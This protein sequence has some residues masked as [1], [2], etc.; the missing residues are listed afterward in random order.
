MFLSDAI[1]DY[2]Y[3]THAK[4]THTQDTREKKV[5]LPRT[6][7]QGDLIDISQIPYITQGPLLHLISSSSSSFPLIPPLP[8]HSLPSS[9]TNMSKFIKS[10]LALVTLAL[11]CLV[12]LTTVKAADADETRESYGTVIGIGKSPPPLTLFCLSACFLV[13]FPCFSLVL[14]LA[15][16]S[17]PAF[18][19]QH[20]L[21]TRNT[22]K[23]G[24]I[25]TINSKKNN[26]ETIPHPYTQPQ[27]K[28]GQKAEQHCGSLTPN[29][30][31]GSQDQDN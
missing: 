25:S 7:F 28:Q 14:L 26:Q 19:R 23:K 2:S 10:T 31:L 16:L 8:P 9:H 13:S 12:A 22:T 6:Q 17:S 20:A 21:R 11:V 29:N 30:V 15:C 1:P 3:Q 27:N 5:T 24:I 4:C 18:H